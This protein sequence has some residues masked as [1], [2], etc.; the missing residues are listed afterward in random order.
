MLNQG[1]IHNTIKTQAYIVMHG[2]KNSTGL[3]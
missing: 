1:Y 3:R 2:N